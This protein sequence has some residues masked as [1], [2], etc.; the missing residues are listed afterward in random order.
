MDSKIVKNVT[1]LFMLALLVRVIY[2]LF[3]VEIEYLFTEDQF[4][5]IQL[6][7][8]LSESGFLGVTPERV[9]GYPFFI[10]IVH[11]LFGES[12]WNI[13]LIQILLD[14]ISCVVIALMA[15][16]IF[17]EGFW[18]AGILS[19]INLNM[20]ILSASILT[21]TLFLFLF[22]LFLFSLLQYLKN[23]QIKWLFLFV[24]FIASL[25]DWFG[26]LEIMAEG[27]YFKDWSVNS[28]LFSGSWNFIR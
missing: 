15:Y 23:E 10:S 3:F 12:I 25:V 4:L 28:A 26:G 22:V 17:R 18:V 14:S 20:V 21:D 27:Y 24:L 11:I 16:S 2:S 1:L 8:Q 5:Y 9:P 7:Q 13:I 6:A 19:A